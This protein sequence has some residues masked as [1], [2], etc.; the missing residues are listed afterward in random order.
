MDKRSYIGGH[1]PGAA[2]QIPPP[3]PPPPPPKTVTRPPSSGSPSVAASCLL[4]PRHTHASCLGTQEHRI[5]HLHA[6]SQR[7]A[8][9]IPYQVSTSPPASS[10]SPIEPLELQ[11]ADGHLSPHST[12]LASAHPGF[13]RAPLT[14]DFDITCGSAGARR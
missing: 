10:A 1:V 13:P 14:S 12:A 9:P 6:V 8:A 4:S 5:I 3:P 2:S 7:Y 11:Y